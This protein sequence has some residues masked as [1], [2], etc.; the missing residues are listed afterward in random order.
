VFPAIIFVSFQKQKQFLFPFKSFLWGPEEF[1]KQNDAKQQ[2]QRPPENAAF[3]NRFFVFSSQTPSQSLLYIHTYVH[4]YN[5]STVRWQSGHRI[6]LR[7]RRS[8]FESRLGVW[9]IGIHTY[10]IFVWFIK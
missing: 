4:M 6:R 10:R 1:G 7:S 9:C 8:G 2:Q 5:V 3:I